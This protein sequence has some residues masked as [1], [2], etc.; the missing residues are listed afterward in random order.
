M[1]I[2]EI[3]VNKISRWYKT[4]SI[5]IECYYINNKNKFCEAD[6]LRIIFPLP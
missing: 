2:N 4:D 1:N 3:S 5:I 6:I